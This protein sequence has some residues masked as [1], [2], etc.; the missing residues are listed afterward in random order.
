MEIMSV[1]KR[2][3]TTLSYYIATV[4]HNYKEKQLHGDTFEELYAS[5]AAAGIEVE[6]GSLEYA[7][8][9]QRS[10][11]KPDSGLVADPLHPGVKVKIDYDD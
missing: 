9:H 11:G 8:K 1:K 2:V 3:T 10:E 4:W 6:P 7:Y 5:L